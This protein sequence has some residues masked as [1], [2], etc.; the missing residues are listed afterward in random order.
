M[1]EETRLDC[2]RP[3]EDLAVRYVSRAMDEAE[4]ESFEDHYFGCP[5]CL[6]RVQALQEARRALEEDA[7]GRAGAARSA[8]APRGVP[9]W[10]MAAA[11]AAVA[12]GAVVAL[13]GMGP[14]SPSPPPPTSTAPTPDARLLELAR[15]E[16]APYVPLVMRGGPPQRAFEEAMARYLDRDFAG[17]AA[18]LRGVLRG[19][20][21]DLEPRFYLG[22]AELLAGDPA[23][24]AGD[25]AVVVR[26][27]DEALAGPATLYLAKAWLA[28]GRVAEA[29]AQLQGLA[30]SQKPQAGAA[31]DLL[32]RLEALG[33]RNG[34]GGG[35]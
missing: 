29:R 16:P 20:P 5:S 25:L 12:V 9:T 26:S 23:A 18:A 10:A 2:D 4:R 3:D 31:R 24:A 35:S 6:G 17:A 30:A 28:V 14:V 19:R 32:A 33:R 21:Q 7:R 22:V 15:A 8:S 34:D 11:L 13:R 1:T 27:Q